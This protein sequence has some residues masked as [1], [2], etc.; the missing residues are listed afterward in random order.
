MQAIIRLADDG[1]TLSSR[2][3]AVIFQG[4]RTSI[5]N[6]PHFFFFFFFFFGGGGGSGHPVLRSGSAHDS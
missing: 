2:L 5:A 1:P 6:K 4:I 3:V